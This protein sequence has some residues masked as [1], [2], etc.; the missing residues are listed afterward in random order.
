MRV[1]DAKINFTY[2]EEAPSPK[3]YFK[4]LY[5]N[6]IRI[7]YATDEKKYCSMY[8]PR[9]CTKSVYL[10]R[11]PAEYRSEYLNRMIEIDKCVERGAPINVIW[12]AKYL[13]AF[14]GAGGSIEIKFLHANVTGSVQLGFDRYYSCSA[15]LAS[16]WVNFE[17]TDIDKAIWAGNKA[18]GIPTVMEEVVASKAKVWE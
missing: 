10:E 18:C 3:K 6:G 16:V 7:Y 13:E 8:P 9:N 4:W 14:F 15:S 2:P 17:R 11:V 5:D 1:E 12:V